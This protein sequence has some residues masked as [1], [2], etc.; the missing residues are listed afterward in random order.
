MSSPHFSPQYHVEYL[1]AELQKLADSYGSPSILAALAALHSQRAQ[2]A[3]RIGR[4]GQAAD[5]YRM[6]TCIRDCAEILHRPQK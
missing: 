4:L 6:A 2:Y 5:E 3:A 1:Y